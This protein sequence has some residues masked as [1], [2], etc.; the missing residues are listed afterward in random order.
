MHQ[1]QSSHESWLTIR[2]DKSNLL[3]PEPHA[4]YVGFE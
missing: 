2:V 1:I 4:E 3:V